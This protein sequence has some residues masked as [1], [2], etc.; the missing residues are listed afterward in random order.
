MSAD[1]NKSNLSQPIG[2]ERSIDPASSLD[3]EAQ[4]V[5]HLLVMK[6]FAD[7]LELVSTVNHLAPTHMEVKPGTIVLGLVLD[8]HPLDKVLG[9]ARS[10]IST[11][12]KDEW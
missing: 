11:T 3:I 1:A 8:T 10:I 2:V 5:D 6:S 4:Q 7:D 12:C 9:L